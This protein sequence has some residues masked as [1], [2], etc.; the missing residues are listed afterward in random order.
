V[1]LEYAPV[2]DHAPTK[3]IDPPGAMAFDFTASTVLT[4]LEP[5]PAAT[6]QP[7]V[8][9][10]GT[11]DSPLQRPRRL[12]AH[13]LGAVAGLVATLLLGILLRYADRLHAMPGSP[14]GVPADAAH[15][16]PANSAASTTVPA[17]T[18]PVR[19]DLAGT[20]QGAYFDASGRQLLR[21]V[22]LSIARVHDD[23]G[24]EGTLQYEAPSGEG[25]CQLHPRGSNW[26]AGRQRLQLSPESCTPHYPR[27]LGVPLD[28]DGVDPQAST[29]RNGRIE[30]PTGEVIRVR[31]KRAT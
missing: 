7:V 1:V 10:T 13:R 30:A 24:I 25:E 27:E 8:A 18:E 26:S 29:L 21:V 3:R 23:G 31:L 6:G 16:Q 20:W 12:R 4:P 2:F 9:S 17:T 15:A 22:T 11:H 19:P 14:P 28:F 5:S